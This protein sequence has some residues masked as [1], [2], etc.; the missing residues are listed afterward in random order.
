L[1]FLQ[2]IPEKDGKVGEMRSEDKLKVIQTKFPQYDD[3][4]WIKVVFTNQGDGVW[5]PSFEDLCEIIRGICKCED[6][7]Y[8]TGQGRYMVLRFMQDVIFTNMT[9]R[10]LAKKYKI[11]IR[12]ER[13]LNLLEVRK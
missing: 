10:E 5:V 1:N 4:D 7:K 8:P 12:E 11:P 3:K 9:F 2:G 6:I 13:Q